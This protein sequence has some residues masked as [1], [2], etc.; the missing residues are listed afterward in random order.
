MPLLCQW[1]EAVAS[2]FL[3]FRK[4]EHVGV[5]LQALGTKEGGTVSQG[6]REGRM[7]G[8]PHLIFI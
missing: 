3:K 1:P 8:L 5:R 6:R 2:G 7:E 4:C